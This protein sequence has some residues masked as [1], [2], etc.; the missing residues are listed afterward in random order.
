LLDS[1]AMRDS[2]GRL[3]QLIVFTE[4]RDTLTYL[5]DQIRTVLGRPESVVA[6]HGGVRREE[7]RRVQDMFTRTRT[8][9]SWSPPTRPARASTC[10]AP[11]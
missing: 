4:H 8:V 2:D 6:I 5:M 7:R 3:R 1:A 9:W 11:T 10:N